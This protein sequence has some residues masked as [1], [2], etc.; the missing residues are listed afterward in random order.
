MSSP[1]PEIG[2]CG[3][4]A[5]GFGMASNLVK[6]GYSVTGFDVAP[7]S[8]ERFKKEGGIPASSL[9]ESAEG[10]PYYVCMV[11]T[12]AQAQ[13]VLFEGDKGIVKALPKGATLLLCSTVPSAYAQSVSQQLKDVGRDDIFFI[14]SP[15]SGGAARAASGTLSIMAGGSDEAL[16][17]GKFLLQEMSDAKKLFIVKGGVGAGSN[18]KMVHQVL[19]AIQIL[20]TSEAFGLAARLGLDAREVRDKVVRS[21][22][23]SWMFENR[24]TRVLEEDYFPGVSALTIILKDVGIITSTAR[25]HN[26]PTPLSSIAEQVY[27]SG[28]AQGFGPNDDAGMVRMY[29]PDP[30]TKVNSTLP[31]EDASSKLNLVVCMLVGIHLCAAAESISFAKH[32]GLPLDQLYELAVDAA[33]GSIMFQECG[34]QMIEDLKGG[35]STLVASTGRRLDSIVQDMLAAVEEAQKTKCPMYLA[36]GSLSLLLM[37]RRGGREASAASVIDVWRV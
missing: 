10:K 16:E 32:V 29:Y 12:A 35:E 27:F 1:K 14:D 19:A 21:E 11:A 20:A 31:K 37:A 23:W 9:A 36:S 4:G 8:L 13:S 25:L 22:A 33:G 34:K 18:M 28:L 15:V 3:L 2:F 30:V 24:S 5:M 7:Q 26:F 17:K 6:Q